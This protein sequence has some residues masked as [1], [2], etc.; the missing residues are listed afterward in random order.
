MIPD[1]KTYIGES[2]WADIHKR[3]NGE[4]VRKEDSVNNLDMKEFCDYLKD[5]YEPTDYFNHDEFDN[6]WLSKNAIYT[7]ISVPAVAT[8]DKYGVTYIHLSLQEDNDEYVMSIPRF[9][10]FQKT[11]LCKL[12][13]KEFV[14]TESTEGFEYIITPK[15]GH[16]DKKLFIEV[17][18]FMIEHG[19]EPQILTVVMKKK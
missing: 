16:V 7:N 12:L 5:H 2:I 15:S 8:I 9:I 11:D 14:L 10:P 19:E 17:L 4:Q 3:S 13:K 18:D 6:Y 1:F